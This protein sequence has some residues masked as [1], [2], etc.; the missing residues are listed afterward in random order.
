MAKR[1][2]DTDKWKKAFIKGLPA[3]YKLFW[4]YLLDECDHAGIWHVEF[5]LAEVRLGVKLSQEK[6]RGLFRERVVV[7]DSGAKWFIPDFISFQYGELNASNR[8]HKSVLQQ[9]NK[10]NLLKAGKVHISPLQGAK[11][12]EQEKDKDKEE[13]GMGETRLPANGFF[14]DE[15]YLQLELP[16]HKAE[17]AA[18]RVRLTSRQSI[19]MTQVY[20]LWDVFKQQYFTGGKYYENNEAIYRHFN[21]WLKD[22]KFTNGNYKGKQTIGDSIKGINTAF[23]NIQRGLDEAMRNGEAH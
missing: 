4:L 19:D 14:P 17:T 15:N 5:D 23:A 10:Y 13:G 6:A 12:K 2:T 11:D 22:Q 9:L 3:E 1:F 20:G 16:K 21:N 7:F 18:E 8:A